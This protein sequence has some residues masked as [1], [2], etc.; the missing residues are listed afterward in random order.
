MQRE[1]AVGFPSQAEKIMNARN[2]ITHDNSLKKF[3]MA[4]TR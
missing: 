4:N 2:Q 1:I 3:L